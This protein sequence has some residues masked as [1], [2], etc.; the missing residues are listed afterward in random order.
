MKR[1]YSR[2]ELYALGEPLGDSATYRKA[3]GLVLGDG[4]GGGSAPAAP[5]K[6]TQTVEL[7]EWAQPYAK[8]VLAR[9]AALTDINQNP[10]QQY[11]GNR[12][13]G[14][15][16]MQMQSF[17]GAANM[18]AGPQGFQEQVGQYM[19]P[20]MQNVVDVEKRGAIRDYQV[21][22]TMQQAQATQAGAFGGGR[23]AIQRAERERG[24]MGTLGGI[25]ARGAQSAFDQASNQF[26]QG[27][28]QGMGINQLQNQYGGQMQQQAQRPLDMAYQDFQN[29]QNYPYK[30]LGFMS[31]LVRGMPLGQ[32]STSTVYESPGS[33]MG[34]LAGLGMGAYG[35]SRM[36]AEGGQVE[37][38]E[39]VVR[40]ADG[41]VTSSQNV[42]G[43][44]SK[45]SDQQLAQAK[46]TALDRRDV[47]QAN[48]IDAEMAQRASIR[49]GLG[50]AF[51]QIPEEQQEQMMAGGGIVAFADRGQV[52][53]VPEKST[54]SIGDF[55]NSI[56]VNDAVNSL[57]ESYYKTKEGVQRMERAEDVLP[58]I[59]ESMTPSERAKRKAAGT[60]MF[61]G[62][63]DVAKMTPAE[64]EAA[65]AAIVGS[66][67]PKAAPAGGL[68]PAE[69]EARNAE[70]MAGSN[71]DK[72]GNVTAPKPSAPQVA[73]KKP[74]GGLSGPKPSKAE[75]KSAVA[76]FAEQN[77]L[78]SGEKEGLMTTA[79]KI[80]EEFGKQNQPILD[81]LNA[82]IEGQKP[83]EQALKDRGIAQ[84]LAQFGFGMA[85]RASKPGARFLES[86]AGASP[87]LAAV[88]D[89]TNSLID[90]QKQNYTN[91]KLDQAKYEVALAKGDMQTAATLAGQIRQQQQ[92]D[93]TL[94]FQIAKAQDDLQ[95][96]KAKLAQTGAYYS[97]A[98][99]R[100]PETVTGLA[101]QLMQDPTFKG[102]Q[103]DAIAQAANM[104]KG[105]I[106]AG[107]RSETALA[108][109]RAK[110]IEKVDAS[111]IGKLFA[112]TRESDPKY[113]ERKKKYD[114]QVLQQMQQLMPPGA[115]P[116]IGNAPPSGGGSN[117]I[118]FN[119]QGNPI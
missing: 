33:T 49:G 63:K 53:E 24:L 45:L 32:K 77:D 110:A 72:A 3:G 44:L 7:P 113:A 74:E 16:P 64:I 48:M 27:I 90:T 70:I 26:R 105:G 56:G 107:I 67:K 66:T 47:E 86:A 94:Q 99:S 41:G 11:G 42:E 62:P 50:G 101:K 54:S 95:I 108:E 37:D 55:L 82:A 12:I 102:T 100:M 115:M 112:L 109:A 119:A 103:N 61:K 114:Q 17:Q 76:K 25:Q 79:L 71:V 59:F 116:S 98:A 14:F 6:T 69:I 52:K 36:M 28:S 93:K 57:R 68:T 73:A 83:N 9:G 65:N 80:R 22:N 34:Q 39:S 51:N 19:S 38:E 18:N 111:L 97:A 96:E 88:A 104:L 106:P 21:G 85:E 60:E 13:A 43:I 31:D 30:Q 29:Q 87:I 2:R 117:I 35:L 1:S 89:K 10:Y 118:R 75:V 46:Q 20:Y 15:S 40:Y 92:Q 23:E 5:D 91:L 84:A 58:G 4:G 81:K 8:N 78:G